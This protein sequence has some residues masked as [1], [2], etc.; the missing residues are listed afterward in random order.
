VTRIKKNKARENPGDIEMS[1]EV[2]M[3]E[4]S[5]MTAEKK[6]QSLPVLT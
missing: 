4:Y 1:S 6:Q 5:E 2:E 3:K